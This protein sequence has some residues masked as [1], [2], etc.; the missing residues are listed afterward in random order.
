MNNKKTKTKT[1]RV[2]VKWSENAIKA[3]LSFLLEHKEKVE[4]LKY[5]RGASSN[6]GNIQ[7][8]KDAEAFLLTFN[9]EQF[10]N[11]IQI[12]NK[13][14]NLVDNYKVFLKKNNVF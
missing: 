1:S 9:F 4:E 14:K 5:T 7:L 8:W 2:R 11:N 10:Y 13:W 12:A 3:L 6:P